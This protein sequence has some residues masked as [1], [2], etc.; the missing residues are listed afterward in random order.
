M[1]KTTRR[2]FV[3]AWFV[4]AEIKN[5]ADFLF[6]SPQLEPATDDWMTDRRHP[7]HPSLYPWD[8]EGEDEN[9]VASLKDAGEDEMERV[10]ATTHG[11]RFASRFSPPFEE[12]DSDEAS[13]R[14]NTTILLI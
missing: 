12:E 3:G 7:L 11:S 14:Y 2:G 9:A 1:C 13:D 10:P 4:Q 5:M 8:D 6:E